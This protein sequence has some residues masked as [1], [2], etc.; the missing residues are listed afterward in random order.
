MAARPHAV[1]LAR[2]ESDSSPRF[3]VHA[4]HAADRRRT[5]PIRMNANRAAFETASVAGALHSLDANQCDFIALPPAL[6]RALRTA[7]APN[8]A[9]AG[10]ECRRRRAGKKT[11]VCG[12]EAFVNNADQLRRPQCDFHL[13]S[14]AFCQGL[15]CSVLP[16]SALLRSAESADSASPSGLRRCRR[17][18]ARAS[19][20]CA[21]IETEKVILFDLSAGD[22][23]PRPV[24]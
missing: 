16:G 3:V 21:G 20:E 24:R 12:E 14:A 11:D 9:D 15:H 10:A 19:I 6:L 13:Q 17:L 22:W 18:R 2:P 4:L 7:S 8:P 1:H 5:E 23:A